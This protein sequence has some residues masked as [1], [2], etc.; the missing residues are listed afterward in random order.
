[1]RLLDKIFRRKPK[2][3]EREA[4]TAVVA[5]SYAQAKSYANWIELKPREWFY[6]RGPE[7]LRGYQFR[8]GQIHFVGTFYDRLDLEEIAVN[9][10]IATRLPYKP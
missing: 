7:D 4:P 9:A 8:P 5:G 10:A 3:V 2:A 6:V 1:M